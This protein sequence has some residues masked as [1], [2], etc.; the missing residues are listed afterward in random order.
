M[1][2]DLIADDGSGAGAERASGE[3]ALFAA[4]ERS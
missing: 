4:A 2:M 1:V 3:S